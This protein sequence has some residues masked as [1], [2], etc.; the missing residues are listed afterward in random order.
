MST[1]VS[2]ISESEIDQAVN[3]LWQTRLPGASAER[4]RLLG[5][6]PLPGATE[7]ERSVLEAVRLH[8]WSLAALEEGDLSE[9]RSGVP[10]AR[11]LWD[12][13]ER[14][15]ESVV[16]EMAARAH[17]FHAR[18]ASRHPAAYAA[19]ARKT[20]SDCAQGAR[21][22]TE[23]IG[24]AVLAADGDQRGAAEALAEIAARWRRGIP[25]RLPG[26]R[27]IELAAARRFDLSDRPSSAKTL[28]NL[29][30][31]ICGRHAAYPEE[32]P[33]AWPPILRQEDLLR[34]AFAASRLPAVIAAEALENGEDES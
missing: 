34:F 14:S 3:R 23:S 24:A 19:L 22:K 28:R 31:T 33:Q 26:L 18:L 21:L 12:S 20:L 7:L 29:A 5:P 25:I 2:P 32:A 17:A 13:V 27:P 8:L 30:R 16:P 1:S 9:A 6:Q 10:K 4:R 11:G 15:I